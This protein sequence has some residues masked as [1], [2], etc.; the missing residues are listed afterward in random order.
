MAIVPVFLSTRGLTGERDPTRIRIGDLSA[1]ENVDF[2]DSL[3]QKDPGAVKINAAAITGTPRV[4]AGAD[5]WTDPTT[6]RRVIAL[7]DGTL[8]KDTMVGTFAVLL[9]SGLATDKR[10]Q[11][12]ECGREGLGNAAK[13]IAFTGADRPQ[14]L[15]GDAAVTTDYATPPVDW[16]GTNQPRFGFMFRGAVLAGG[17]D[18]NP[19]LLYASLGTNHEDM[20]AIGTYQLFVYP[21]EGQRLVAGITALGRGWVWKYPVGV[22]WINDAAS[23]ITGWYVQPASREYG[24]IDSPHCV[25]Q[26]DQGTIAFL[27]HTGSVVIMQESSGT[28]S[29][30]DFVDLMKALSLQNFIR[31]N[32]NLARLPWSQMRWY[33]D[34]K[35]LHVTFASPGSTIQDRRM[36][37]DFNSERTRV[38][39]SR[40]ETCESL[41]LEQDSDRIPRPV[42][43]DNVGFVRKLGQASRL[44]DGQ[45]YQFR[46]LTAPTDF[47]DIDG[48]YA[49]KKN[50]RK[51]HMEYEATGDYAVTVAVFIDGRRRGSYSFKM[52]GGGGAVLP[53]ALPMVLGSTELRRR[54]RAICGEGWYCS[55][56]ITESSVNNPKLARAWVEF[57]PLGMGR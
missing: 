20:T 6:Q 25:Q 8:R 10:V 23:S 22:Y 7:G 30:V 35:Q 38:E 42:A 4:I 47:S 43:G 52:S 49:V 29:G 45:P 48:G 57:D 55:L 17:N 54:T 31:E 32:F 28:L 5:F 13:L 1:A 36:V 50:F 21:G 11:L 53:F 46:L 2:G 27:N 34:K 40:K 33:N 18:N 41:W 12:L 26:V 19:H 24:A 14:V 44:V 3:L 39:V 15:A 51:L 37:I 9:K 16:T 56:E